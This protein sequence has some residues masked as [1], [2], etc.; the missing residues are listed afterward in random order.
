MLG[1]LAL[2]EDD[3]FLRIDAGGNECRRD[4]ANAGGQFIRVL[5]Q[6]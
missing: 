6:R 4:L 1:D 2:I 5:R 3:M